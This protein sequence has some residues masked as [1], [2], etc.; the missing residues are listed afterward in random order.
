M[1]Y[2]R[3]QDDPRGWISVETFPNIVFLIEHSIFTLNCVTVVFVVPLGLGVMAF[4]SP[5]PLPL[6]IQNSVKQ[7][8]SHLDEIWEN[9][10]LLDQNHL[11]G[12]KNQLWSLTFSMLHLECFSR[13]SAA[14]WLAIQLID[15]LR[16]C[17]CFSVSGSI[18]ECLMMLGNQPGKDVWLCFWLIF[19]PVDHPRV[20]SG[21]H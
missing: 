10:S 11:R 13:A 21:V 18:N 8:A 3:L 9:M 17:I 16:P 12:Y 1:V 20:S 14:G 5:N 15:V 6:R 4:N 2:L 7:S 19:N